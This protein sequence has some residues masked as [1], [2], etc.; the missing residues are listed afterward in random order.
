MDGIKPSTGWCEGGE[1]RNG[2]PID[3]GSLAVG[4][5]LRPSSA[6]F[7]DVRPDKSCRVSRLL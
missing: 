1:W 4:A 5:G 3:L 7:A 2:V 6:V